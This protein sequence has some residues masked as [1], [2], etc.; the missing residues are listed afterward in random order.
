M[1]IEY[2]SS[3]GKAALRIIGPLK[4]QKIPPCC[5]YSRSLSLVLALL[6]SEMIVISCYI[7]VA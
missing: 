5:R 6:V 7:L 3:L 2:H 1:K 4:S